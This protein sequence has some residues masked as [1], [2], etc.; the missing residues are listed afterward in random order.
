MVLCVFPVSFRNREKTESASASGCCQPQMRHLRQTSQH[1][2]DLETSQG[3]AA[4]SATEQRSMQPLP[5]SVQDVK[6]PKQS[7][8]HLSPEA[9]VVCKLKKK[10]QQKTKKERNKER[11]RKKLR[12]MKRSDDDNNN[13][14]NNL[15]YAPMH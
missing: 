7:Q 12:N 1:E 6:F 4:H 14:N 9:E 13:N 11:K 2:A 10:K 3:A 5:Q 8:K 15:Y